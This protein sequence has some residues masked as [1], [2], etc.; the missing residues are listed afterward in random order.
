MLLKFESNRL[1]FD[2][3]RGLFLTFQCIKYAHSARP[4]PK[5]F[6]Q[7]VGSCDIVLESSRR[8]TL[9]GKIWRESIM[10]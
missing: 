6:F 9:A 2:K 4:S 8:D 1:R 5:A 3:V 7:V 10:I